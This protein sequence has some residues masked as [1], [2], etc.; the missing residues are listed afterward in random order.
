[1]FNESIYYN[2]AYGRAGATEAE[3]KEAAKL[4]FIDTLLT[5]CRKVMTLWLVREV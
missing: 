1:M 3:V 2:I 4:S 5:P